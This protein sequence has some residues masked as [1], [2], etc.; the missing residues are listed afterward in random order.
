MKKLFIVR[1]YR[2]YYYFKYPSI[3]F[4]K[5]YEEAVHKFLTEKRFKILNPRKYKPYPENHP[6]YERIDVDYICKGGEVTGS[7]SVKIQIFNIFLKEKWQ[8]FL[9]EIW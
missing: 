4:A 8:K 2:F 9:K 5:N 7:R 6:N 3:I 1:E